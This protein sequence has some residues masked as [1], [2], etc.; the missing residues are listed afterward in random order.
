MTTLSSCPW[1]TPQPVLQR[2][3]EIAE[4]ARHLQIL[5]DPIAYESADLDTFLLD[6]SYDALL[7]RPERALASRLRDLAVGV[8]DFDPRDPPGH[9]PCPP[10][11]LGTGR[12]RWSVIAFSLWMRS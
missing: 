2:Q 7:F 3:T 8:G 11:A 5:L 4:A 12:A 10:T 6:E 9:R 1:R